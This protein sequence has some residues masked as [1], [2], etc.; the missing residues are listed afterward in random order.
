M[1]L[2]RAPRAGRERVALAA[3][4]GVV[5][6]AT[7]VWLLLAAGPASVPGPV[8]VAAVARAGGGAG[9][10]RRLDDGDPRRVHM[11]AL[12][13]ATARAEVGRATWTLLHTV[14]A[15]FPDEPTEEQQADLAAWIALLAR[16]YPC[17]QCAEEFQA[18]LAANPPEVGQPHTH[19]HRE[20]ETRGP[21]IRRAG[22]CNVSV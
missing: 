8:S 9:G 5:G 1:L 20:R 19:T 22:L 3:L 4:A 18:I 12:G 21:S 10:F 2:L 16:L 14:A 15:R 13:N 11:S 6:L 17:G 7:L